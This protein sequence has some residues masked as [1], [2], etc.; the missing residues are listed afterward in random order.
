MKKVM[1]GILILI[2][3]I[4]L[5]IVALVTNIV[6]LNAHIAVEDLQLTYKGT[7]NTAYLIPI[8]IQGEICLY[9]YVDAKIYPEQ[10]TDKTI[11]WQIA[12][13]VKYTDTKYEDEYEQY[14][15]ELEKFKENLAN[16]FDDNLNFTS[17]EKA[18][19]D[20]VREEYYYDLDEK[21]S[22]ISAM[23][24]RLFK[25][26]AVA[27]AAVF[28]D[29]HGNEVISNTSG[30]MAIGAHCNFTVRAV[31]E[32]VSRTISISIVGYDVEQVVVSL[33]EGEDDALEIGE[34]VR[35]LASYT[36]IQS[37]VNKTKW[38]SS[39]ENVAV[40]DENGV[41]TAVGVGDA[42]ITLEASIH[43]TEE[44]EIK[45]KSGEISLSVKSSGLSTVFGNRV[46]VSRNARFTLEQLG[47]KA[48]DVD[49]SALDKHDDGTYSLKDGASAT[50]SVG[51]KSL[52]IV[53]CANDA[54]EIQHA[55]L[56]ENGNYVLS[57]GENTLKLKAVWSD[58][59]KDSEAPKVK[60]KSQNTNIAI[61]DEESGVV[62]GVG[63]GVVEIRA[64][65]G[66]EMCCAIQLNVRQKLSSIQLRTSDE[67]LAV[68][69]ARETVFAGERYE[70]ISTSTKKIANST[71]VVVQSEPSD[72]DADEIK[73]FYDAFTFEIVEGAEYASMDKDVANK[74]VFNNS[75]LEGKDKQNVVV[76]VKAK[77]PKYEG[78]TTFT[79]EDVTLVAVF[80]VQ[81]GNMDE[82]QQ[83]CK[84][85]KK[86]VT[87]EDNV[88]VLSEAE[89]E[90]WSCES[91]KE[92]YKVNRDNHS[93]KDFAI[94][95]E[96]NCMY[97]FAKSD[98]DDYDEDDE[99]GWVVW[100]EQVAFY[101]NVY[102]N[103]NKIS[104]KNGAVCKVDN[105]EEYLVRVDRGGVTISNLVLRAGEHEFDD[106]EEVDDDRSVIFTGIVCLVNAGRNRWFADD[107]NDITF[108]YSIIENSNK[109]VELY[110]TDINF[111][112]CVIRNMMECGIY[113]PFRMNSTKGETDA[114]TGKQIVYP[115]YSHINLHNVICS[116][117]LGS[118]LSVA[119]EAVTMQSSVKFRFVDGKIYSGDDEQKIAES[120]R[121]EA[122]NEQ[123]FMDNFYKKGINMVVNQ[124]G[125]L[126]AYNWM[127]VKDAGLIKTGS[128]EL[129][130]LIGGW[131]DKIVDGDTETFKDYLYIAEDGEKYL[132][133]SFIVTG[134]LMPSIFNQKTYLQLNQQDTDYNCFNLQDVDFDKVDLEDWDAIKTI[135]KQLSLKVYGYDNKAD[136][137][138]FSTYQ[139]NAALIAE[140]HK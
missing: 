14:K 97:E 59:L 92:V 131:F 130:A 31:A 25:S 85:Q 17:E 139:L 113:A 61:V 122:Q 18:V 81:V 39:N 4:I 105:T 10:A 94:V 67:A 125:F 1:I 71:L 72:A 82:L 7:Q 126:R 128:D 40:V 36:P 65:N 117:T 68:G 48:E 30:K 110:N 44:G 24:D 116:N 88:A 134:I 63:D 120:K 70:D 58:M 12:G 115:S 133:F 3:I 43:S 102:G 38:S 80:G 140:L 8:Q 21:D 91:E 47:I 108:E 124:T 32:N 76:R 53:P 51:G 9:D 99:I 29:E 27:P 79:T 34:S 50:L 35:L 75:A 20:A 6:S 23:A 138:P 15:G 69:L 112:G 104:A 33:P 11:E 45:F 13:D 100:D 77:Y 60:W 93:I 28:V 74:V 132:H 62:T 106:G 118:M 42:T 2:P 55:S 107:G 123:F 54:I 89:K 56:F 57:V 26:K 16:K 37:I 127:N 73:A 52:E 135:L 101:G 109:A 19:Y 96:D 121:L 41:V 111:K 66:D 103:N 95:L 90:Y 49:V 87:S 84:D 136:I 114:N 5:L 86:Y 98:D 129:D 83:A 78:V 137:N 46:V 22:I 64:Y 119:Y